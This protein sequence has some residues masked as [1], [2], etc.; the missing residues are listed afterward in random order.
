MISESEVETATDTAVSGCA[1]ASRGLGLRV[2][3]H[4]RGN[5]RCTRLRLACVYGLGLRGCGVLTCSLSRRG[6]AWG[7]RGFQDR[8]SQ[9]LL[10]S[11]GV[12]SVSCGAGL[13]H[14]YDCECISCAVRARAVPGPREGWSI[15]H[16]G[17][18]QRSFAQP[19][20]SESL[21]AAAPRRQAGVAAP[22]RRDGGG[23][24]AV[25]GQRQ[26]SPTPRPTEKNFARRWYPPR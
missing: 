4:L 20:R 3:Q 7:G 17:C 12:P 9:Q 2:Q 18:K 11:L 14:S 25:E 19:V 15:L 8:T 1:R 26:P 5:G 23:G 6:R 22:A 21:F 13:T 10:C 16:R 24:V